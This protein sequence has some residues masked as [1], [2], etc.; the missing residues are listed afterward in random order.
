MSRAIYLLR[1]NVWCGAIM[2]CDFFYLLGI[3]EFT[4]FKK[5]GTSY[6]KLHY[7]RT[8]GL[9]KRYLLKGNFY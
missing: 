6:L 8:R 9:S 5:L 4:R 2:N 3:V 1:L 7:I